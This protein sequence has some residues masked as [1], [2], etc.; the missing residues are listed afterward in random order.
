MWHYFIHFIVVGSVSQSCDPMDC[1]IPGFLVLHHFLEFAQ[2]SAHWVGDAQPT[3]SSPTVTLSSC[4]QSF[5]ASGSFLM[6]QLFPL[7]LTGL[8]SL[9]SKGLSRVFSNTT[10][11]HIPFYGWVIFHYI[12]IYIYIS[13]IFFSHSCVDGHLGCFFV[14]AMVNSDAVNI[15]LHICF[16]VIVLCGYML[17]GEVAASE[18]N[19]SLSF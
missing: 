13:H 17:R 12:Y 5:P 14:L 8:S 15:G 11:H 19:S 16:P 6:S 4:L 1:S 3:I 10:V 9:Q 2:T 18:D 7:G